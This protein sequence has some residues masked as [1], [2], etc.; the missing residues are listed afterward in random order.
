[1]EVETLES[2]SGGTRSPWLLAPLALVVLA[3]LLL[4][5]QAF[6]D[7]GYS[8]EEA[9]QIDARWQAV[10]E[11][12]EL[13]EEAEV[14]RAVDRLNQ[15]EPGEELAPRVAEAVALL[16]GS[17]LFQGLRLLL[18]VIE[19]LERAPAP[20]LSPELR[21]TPTD[22]HRLLVND[23]VK[24]ALEVEAAIAEE[25]SRVEFLVR[26]MH[27]ASLEHLDSL[28]AAGGNLDALGALDPPDSPAL[29]FL[30]VAASFGGRQTWKR[31]YASLLVPSGET[32][33]RAWEQMLERWDRALAGE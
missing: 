15:W 5:W 28:A 32:R 14:E 24:L 10:L 27:E 6:A 7:R 12:T 20:R 26:V 29:P 22:L 4:G 21:P 2:H 8:E 31:H 17:N 19:T 9:D 13:V 1:M 30:V 3:V 18:A 11:S 16:E 33:V 23:A 25:D